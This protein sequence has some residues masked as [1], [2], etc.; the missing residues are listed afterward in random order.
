MVFQQALGESIPELIESRTKT[1]PKEVPMG[2]IAPAR[3]FFHIVTN[4]MS[5][6]TNSI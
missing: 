1:S 2:R 3:E 6:V 4:R 5:P